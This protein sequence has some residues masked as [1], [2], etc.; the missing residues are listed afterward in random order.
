[1]RIPLFYLTVFWLLLFSAIGAAQ[2]YTLNIPIRAVAQDATRPVPFTWAA[3]EAGI[4]RST[5]TGF[6]WKNIY[7]RPAGQTQP[8][9]KLIHIDA[10]NPRIIYLVS[11]FDSGGIWK[12]VDG[13]TEWKQMNEGLPTQGSIDNFIALPAAPLTFY[14]RM[15]SQIFKTVDG[16]VNWTK[17]GNL[18]VTGT[19]AF[20]VNRAQPT[21]MF[22]SLN[23]AVYRS[24]DEGATWTLGQVLNAGTITSILVDP[25]DPSIV[26]MT[27]A[28]VRSARPGLYRSTDGGEV[29][30]LAG[31]FDVD[32][33]LL[34]RLIADPTGRAI[35]ANYDEDAFIFRTLNK[36][37][38]WE[39]LVIAPGSGFATL[40]IDPGDPRILL[41][42][43]AKGIYK[44]D[45]SGTSWREVRGAA[46]PTVSLPPAPLDF[47]LPPDSQGRLQMLLRV[48]E[49]SQWTLPVSASIQSGS[50]LKLDGTAV[51]TPA[52]PFVTVDTRGLEPGEHTGAV[53]V[54]SAPS[55]N[56]PVTI[57]VKLTVIPPRPLSQSYK[58]TTFAGSGQRGN[59]G[60]NAAATRAFFGDLDSAVT[61]KDGNVYVT[62]PSS[63][64]VRRIGA[65]GV[66]TRF[67]GNARR[68]DSGDDGPALLA[69]LDTPTG[70]AADAAGNIYIA[71]SGNAKIKRVSRDGNI[72]TMARDVGP[73]R[74]IGVDSGGN[75]YVTVPAAHVVLRINPEG[76]GTV[77]AGSVGVGGF[78]GDGG[79]PGTALLSGPQDIFVDARDRV[80]IADTGNHRIRRV[81][82][83]VITTVAGSGIKGY[84]GDGPDATKIALSSPGGVAA[85]ADGNLYIADA[86][87]NRIRMVR[88]DGSV[89]TLAG[90]GVRG[91]TGD[92]G[93]A[94]AAQIAGPLDVAV[95]PGGNVYSVEPANLRIRRLEPPPPPVL[96]AVTEGPVNWADG[97]TRLAPGTIFLL[98]GTDLAVD[99]A[100]RS[101]APWPTLLAGAQITLNGQLVPLWQVSPTEIAGM[102]PYDAAL[103]AGQ[104]IALRDEAP[105]AAVTVT[106][107]PAAPALIQTDPGHVLA[108][109]EDGSANWKGAPAAPGSLVSVYFTG[110]GLPENPP[111]GGAGAGEDSKLLLPVL[112]QFGELTVEPVLARLA[113]GRVG[114]AE[115]QFPVPVTEAGDYPVAVRVGDVL[116]ASAA[117]SV[118]KP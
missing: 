95:G 19:G 47:V 37:T 41:V 13:G 57:P 52:T 91:F 20:E 78:A 68:G 50:W 69:Q 82:A 86:E 38:T 18:P 9:I 6:D 85:D 116:S 2:Q 114:L 103:G 36:G 80:F 46:K 35:Y 45:N 51:N 48:L 43:T 1:M 111:A 60:D 118:G 117:L 25:S 31:T 101:D 22:A 33:L 71:D 15:G 67:A 79:G 97:S 40:A 14:V 55:A 100:I 42:G 84:Q 108:G 89:R 39:A 109:N 27:I 11:N 62:D 16:A 104:L 28:G 21:L 63:H 73:C 44:S 10:A 93:L 107:D 110:A 7:I 34:S 3:T 98:R 32:R 76:R 4:F 94:V 58:I 70:I 83:G 26:H 115:V 56:A 8:V 65:D 92:N 75:M 61:D 23:N 106:I 66:I 81:A 90:T 96:P 17:L 64:V 49:T 5:E 30:S 102:I 105:S 29:F 88:V 113:P 99:K 24:R 72:K 87:N 74:G 12:T 112:V 77:Y 59:F 54:E 53:R